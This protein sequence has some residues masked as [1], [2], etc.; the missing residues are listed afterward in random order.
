[1]STTIKYKGTTIASMTTDS[2]KTLQTEGKYCEANIV[3]E[4]ISDGGTAPSGTIHITENG[5]YDVSDYAAAHVDVPQAST[6]TGSIEITSNG[7]YDVTDKAQAVVKVLNNHIRYTHNNPAAVSG[8]GNY[9]TIVAGDEQLASIRGKESLIVIFRAAGAAS[10]TKSG[11]GT[12]MSTLL[13][14]HNAVESC[15][16]V[17]RLNSAGGPTLS[18]TTQAVNDDTNISVGSGRIYITPEGDLRIYGNTNGYPIL[19]GEIV[20]DVIW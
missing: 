13:P 20:V 8:G 12:N 11:V 5:D 10:C 14:L 9:V 7:T 17:N 15:Q 3:V 16:A 4:N 6:P 1:M 19:A 2:T 18:S